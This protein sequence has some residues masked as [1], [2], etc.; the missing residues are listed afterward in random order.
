MPPSLSISSL[1]E[2]RWRVGNRAKGGPKGKDKPGVPHPLC[3]V[4]LRKHDPYPPPLAPQP[5]VRACERGEVFSP[6]G[7][8]CDLSDAAQRSMPQLESKLWRSA[9][10]RGMW[11]NTRD[12]RARTRHAQPWFRWS[13]YGIT[14]ERLVDLVGGGSTD[15]IKYDNDGLKARLALVPSLVSRLR[16]LRLV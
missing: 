7:R 8:V 1:A 11:A 14:V 5:C 10:S 6:Q 3:S 2:A 13:F 9:G 16:S 15:G 12:L 4:R